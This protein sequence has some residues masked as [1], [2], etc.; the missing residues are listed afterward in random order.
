MWARLAFMQLPV[1]QETGDACPAAGRLGGSQH[2]RVPA[3]EVTV[4]VT[5]ALNPEPQTWVAE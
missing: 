2:D 4:R 5:N 1:E 3:A